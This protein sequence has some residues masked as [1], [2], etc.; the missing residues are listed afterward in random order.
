MAPASP[1]DPPRP[2]LQPVLLPRSL[3]RSHAPW[4]APAASGPHHTLSRSLRKAEAIHSEL[5][6]EAV[7]SGPSICP[8]SVSSISLLIGAVVAASS[9]LSKR[10]DSSSERSDALLPD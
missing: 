7:P 4:V 8:S 2:I 3:G 9:L 6:I 5:C 10:P 1:E